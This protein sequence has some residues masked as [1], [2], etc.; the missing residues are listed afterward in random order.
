[1]KYS[2]GYFKAIWYSEK[3]ARCWQNRNLVMEI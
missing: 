3:I 2:V 1:V